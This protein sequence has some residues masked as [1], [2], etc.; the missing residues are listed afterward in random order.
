VPALKAR[1]RDLIVQ[2]RTALAIAR[3]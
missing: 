2:T 3:R 1:I